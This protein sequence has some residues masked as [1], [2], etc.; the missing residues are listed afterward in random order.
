MDK[1]PAAL[2]FD[3]DGVLADTEPLHWKSWA[4][5]LARYEIPF[6]WEDYCRFGRGVEDTRICEAFENRLPASARGELAR[7]NLDRKRMVCAWSLETPPIPKETVELLGALG[8]YR[9]G[10][11]TSSKRTEVEPVLKASAIYERFNAMVFG[12]D[13]AAH[14]PAPDP[15]LLIAQRLGVPT[16]IAFEDSEPGIESARAAGFKVVKVEHTHDLARIVNRHLAGE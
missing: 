15:Y 3:Y 4:A 7:Q 6:T 13:V 1:K 11:V 16:G 10:L 2:V 9:I 12:E 14:K 5:L 8:E